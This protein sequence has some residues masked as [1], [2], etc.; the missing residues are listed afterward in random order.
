MPAYLVRWEIDVEANS[1]KEAAQEAL[2]IQQDFFSEATSF[3][4]RKNSTGKIYL[5]DLDNPEKT[6]DEQS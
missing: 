1:P 6:E 4:V 5:I 3:T 2:E